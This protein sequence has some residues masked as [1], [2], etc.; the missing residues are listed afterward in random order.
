[1]TTKTTTTI[2]STRMNLLNED[3]ARAHIAA[4]LEEAREMRPGHRAVRA[5]RLSR[6]AERAAQGPRHHPRAEAP[7]LLPFPA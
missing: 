5:R 4:R 3:L 7:P 2:R 1:M 6:R